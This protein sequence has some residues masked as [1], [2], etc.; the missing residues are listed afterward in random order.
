VEHLDLAPRLREEQQ[1]AA[2]RQQQQQQ[3]QQQQQ[4]G[5]PPG[6]PASPTPS[7]AAATADL[8]ARHHAADAGWAG[9]VSLAAGFQRVTEPC[10]KVRQAAL[11]WL[12]G[13]GARGSAVPAA[14]AGS[15][16]VCM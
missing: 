15:V 10:P 9:C 2:V 13:G 16:Q 7:A 3:V 14:R 11:R 12:A 8:L 4:A 5:Q 1:A 6:Q